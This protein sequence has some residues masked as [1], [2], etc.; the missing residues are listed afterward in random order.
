MDAAR[1]WRRLTRSASE[2]SGETIGGRQYRLVS[3]A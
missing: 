2:L 3:G 1:V